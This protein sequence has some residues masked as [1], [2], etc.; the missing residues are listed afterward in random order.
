LVNNAQSLSRLG[1]TGP[2]ADLRVQPG[3]APG[4]RRAIT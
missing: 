3:G 4:E 2:E 1:V